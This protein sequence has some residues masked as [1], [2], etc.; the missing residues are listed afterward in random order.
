MMDVVN[1][2]AIAG[3]VENP[4]PRKPEI[5]VVSVSLQILGVLS[6]MLCSCHAIL[7][8]VFL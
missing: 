3:D 8:L 4:S 6:A 1:S 2:I 5:C 7:Q